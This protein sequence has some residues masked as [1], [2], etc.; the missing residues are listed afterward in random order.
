[1][2]TNHDLINQQTTNS[3]SSSSDR[4]SLNVAVSFVSCLFSLAN[5]VHF[6][7]FQ[8]CNLITLMIKDGHDTYARKR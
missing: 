3:T 5:Y 6:V 2:I 1:M 7:L 8:V 4:I